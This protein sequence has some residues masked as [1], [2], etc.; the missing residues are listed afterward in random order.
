MRI[1]VIGAGAAGLAS[2]W[3]L[4]DNH[5][6]TLLEKQNRLGGHA[7]TI[8]VERDG[9]LI[10]V[11]AG[12]EFFSERMY[13]NFYRLLTLL[14]VPLQKHP[15]TATFSAT[16]RR[17]VTLLPPFRN[18]K[19]I[20]S[21]L[22]PRALSEM[23]QLARVLSRA[24]PLMKAGDT[25]V[26]LE[27]FLDDLSLAPSLKDGFIYPFLLAGWCVDPDEFKHFSAYDVL[28]YP[29]LHRSSGLTPVQWAEVVGGTQAYINALAQ[30]LT[31]TQ[32]VLA[33]NITGIARSHETFIVSAADGSTHQF[34]Q[35]IV[36]THASEAYEL[37]APLDGAQA[38]RDIL[39]QFEYFRTTIAVH[40][41]RRLMPADEQHW[42]VANIRYDGRNSQNT[43]WKRWKSKLP[44]FKS[45]ST[46]ESHMP[47]PLYAAV[48]YDH[49]KVNRQYFEA[50]RRLAALQGKDGLWFAGMY[51][52]DVDSHESAVTSG[53]KVAQQLDPQSTRL[54]RLLGAP[55]HC[56]A[57]V[58][59]QR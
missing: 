35:L 58:T 45:W 14:R 55:A 20:W 51:T 38:A 25:S 56:H 1:G 28:R 32:V 29:F 27:Q 49:P 47:E 4:D 37:L 41:D 34:D 54:K 13:P 30:D 16:G 11:D 10:A 33:A 23:L 24:A 36:A 52:H 42:S 3:L 5:S 59:I 12:F 9:E 46:Y 21:G 39:H 26:T 7:E 15:L 44:I 57:P 40:G 22:T 6:V 50:Q 53:I 2:A 18:G 8:Q 31:H 43:I 17:A 48:T 19:L